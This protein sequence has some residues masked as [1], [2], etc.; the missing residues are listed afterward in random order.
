MKREEL[1]S[2]IQDLKRQ[3]RDAK[4]EGRDV[5]GL[6]KGLKMYAKQIADMDSFEVRPP[7]KLFRGTKKGASRIDLSG[8]VN[9]DG[10]DPADED[11]RDEL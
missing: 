9:P 11:W 6:Q 4:S 7:H 10:A 1:I 2:E 3:I 5:K 8:Y